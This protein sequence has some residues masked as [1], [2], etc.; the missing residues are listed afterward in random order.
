MILVDTSVLIG[1]LKGKRGMPYDYLEIIIDKN[2][3]F[4]IC[5]HVYQELLQGAKNDKEFCELKEYLDDL[6]FYELQNGRKS[7]EEAALMY[8]KCRKAGITI[9]S[10]MDMIIAQ[11]TIENQLYLLHNDADYN[12]IAKIIPDLK[13]I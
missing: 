11:I 6:T 1:Y 12:N 8:M 4:G 2:I 7:Y 10:S 3:P 13:L 9:R 5:N